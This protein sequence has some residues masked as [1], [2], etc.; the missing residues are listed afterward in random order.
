MR[1]TIDLSEIA[2]LTIT[3]FGEKQLNEAQRAAWYAL[4]PG[5]RSAMQREATKAAGDALGRQGRADFATH[6]EK[7]RKHYAAMSTDAQQALGVAHLLR[8]PKVPQS[9]KRPRARGAGRPRASATRS[10]ARSGDSGDDSEGSEPPGRLCACGCRSDI[11]HR[12]PQAR[13]LNEQHAA[14]VR[15][16]RKRTRARDWSPDV[17]RRDPYLRFD[18]PTLEQLRQ[19]IEQGCRCNGHHI[20][21]A[22][23]GHCVKCGHRRGWFLPR[24]ATPPARSAETRRPRNSEVIA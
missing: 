18:V 16:R 12:A 14:A 2:R 3:P 1:T 11:G 5:K 23:D 15:Q 24:A 4:T 7:A 17:S 20:A 21:D 9:Q 22:E 10:S 19:R 6:P 8:A 13:Y